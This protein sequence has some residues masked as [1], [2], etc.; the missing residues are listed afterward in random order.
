[1]AWKFF[2][3]SGQQK[4]NS[5][6]YDF[7]TVSSASSIAIANNTVN[8]VTGTTTISSMTNGVPGSIVTLQASGQANGT[9]LILANGTGSNNLSLRDNQNFGIYAGESVTFQY[10]GFKWVEVNRNIRT[11]LQ[12][13]RVTTATTITATTSTSGNSGGTLIADLGAM[14]FDGTTPMSLEY[15]IPYIYSSLNVNGISRVLFWQTSPSSIQI[16]SY[17]LYYQPDNAGQEYF[18]MKNSYRF[19][20]SAGSATYRLTAN[21]DS[22]GVSSSAAVAGTNNSGGQCTGYFR[23]ARSLS[24]A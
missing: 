10:N 16:S 20:P 3:N 19:T 9:C 6:T 12:T 15:H 8:S 2:N 17:F 7:A 11:I 13:V 1:M 23:I 24:Y 22:S 21:R 4:I 5:P 14:S 18:S